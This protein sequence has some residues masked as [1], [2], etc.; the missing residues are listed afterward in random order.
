MTIILFL[1]QK[2]KAF[3]LHFIFSLTLTLDN[4]ITMDDYFGTQHSTSVGLP[5]LYIPSHKN[6]MASQLMDTL[7]S[8]SLEPYRRIKLTSPL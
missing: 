4:H 7:V 6:K 8:L 5:F 2:Q 3:T 1:T